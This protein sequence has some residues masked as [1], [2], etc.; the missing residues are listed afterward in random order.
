MQLVTVNIQNIWRTQKKK[1]K[2]KAPNK[3]MKS[4]ET[5]FFPENAQIANNNLNRCSVSL[6]TRKMQIKTILICHLPAVV[7]FIR[8]MRWKSCEDLEK[9]EKG[10]VLLLRL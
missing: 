7:F 10:Y 9:K 6:N 8:T 5:E 1:S 4:L 3:N 2:E